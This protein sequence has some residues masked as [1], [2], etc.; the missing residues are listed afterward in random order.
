MKTNKI[1]LTTSC[2]LLLASVGG[3]LTTVELAKLTLLNRNS[4]IL[5]GGGSEWFWGFLQFAIVGVTLIFIYNQL[6]LSAASHVLQSMTSLNERWSSDRNTLLRKR[7]CETWLDSGALISEGQV[8]LHFF[9]ELGLYVKKQWIPSDVIWETYSWYVESYWGMF[10]EHICRMRKD[11]NDPSVFQNFEHLA[12]LM[13]AINGRK[14][15]PAGSK[16]GE[17]LRAFALGE[18]NVCLMPGSVTG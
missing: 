6:N 7:T 15:V 14:G 18:I 3:A 9:E 13:R 1:L 2:V 17:T 5:F 10:E 11:N 8:L 12:I 4:W 16:A